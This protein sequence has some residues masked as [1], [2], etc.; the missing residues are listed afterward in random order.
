M[1]CHAWYI[2]DYYTSV[3]LVGP[4]I[5]QEMVALDLRSNSHRGSCSNCGPLGTLGGPLW[6]CVDRQTQWIGWDVAP[7]LY[8]SWYL[9][10]SLIEN[11]F[12]QKDFIKFLI[13]FSQLLFLL[14]FQSSTELV[15]E[16]LESQNSN[17]RQIFPK[18]YFLNIS[19]VRE[20]FPKI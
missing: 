2:N 10:S 1:W 8:L 18:I 12:W 13:D 11:L 19:N 4:K 15:V 7:Y 14:C 6:T 5:H 17:V 9:N 3:N 16:K 20:I